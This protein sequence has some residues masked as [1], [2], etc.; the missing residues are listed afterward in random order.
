MHAP[1][2]SM[3]F[4][5]STCVTVVS[6]RCRAACACSSSAALGGM[7]LAGVL[8]RRRDWASSPRPAPFAGWSHPASHLQSCQARL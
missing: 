6:V 1:V 8:G 4:F 2:C 3:Y 5:P 7:A